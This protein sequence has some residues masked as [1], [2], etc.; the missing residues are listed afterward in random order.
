M[1]YLLFS[2]LLLLP[3]R[4]FLAT[5]PHFKAPPSTPFPSP[6]YFGGGHHYFYRLPPIISC[7]LFSLQ[8]LL[9]SWLFLLPSRRFLATP[10]HFK[11]PPPLILKPPPILKPPLPPPF[12]HPFIPGGGGVTSLYQFVLIA[13]YYQLPPIFIAISAIF[14]AP[15]AAIPALFGDPPPI[16]KPH[17]P[18]F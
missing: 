14:I 10:P 13:P 3:T 6:L 7:P 1:R 5:P 9:F 15:F 17:P 8:Y 2:L 4:C 11:A 18:L 12:L 16:S